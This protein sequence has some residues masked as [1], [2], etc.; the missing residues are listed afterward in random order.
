MTQ[1]TIVIQA[2]QAGYAL[3]ME[4]LFRETFDPGT[5]RETCEQ[6]LHAD[7]YLRHMALFPEGQHV[8]VE[9]STDR[10]VGLTSSMRVPFDPGAPHLESWWKGI[11]EGW[12]S[13]HDPAGEWLYGVETIVHDEYRGRGI[14][15]KLMEVRRDLIR[16]ANL[17][18]MIAGSIP[19]DY[20]AHADQMP[21][22]TYVEAVAAGRLFDTNL[23][24]QLHMGFRPVQII[25]DYVI[26]W[27]PRRYGVLIC[28]D[29]P[30]YSSPP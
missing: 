19:I 14:G 8:A 17:R 4:E 27:A 20:D 6:C 11:G 26:D 15:R 25:P 7:H 21:I 29:N 10:V 28:W 12:L 9:A 23:S 22:E 30:D 3:Q 13:T 1:A 2:A 16:R 24:K 18:G 5:T